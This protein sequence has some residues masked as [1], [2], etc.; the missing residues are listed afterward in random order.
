MPSE[1]PPLEAH[2][3]PAGVRPQEADVAGVVLH[4][5]LDVVAHL[6]RPVLVVTDADHQVVARQQAR[7]GVQVDR[8]R[9]VD[10]RGAERV[11]EEADRPYEVAEVHFIAAHTVRGVAALPA[12]P[13]TVESHLVGEVRG[14]EAVPGVDVA[15]AVAAVVRVGKAGGAGVVTGATPVVVGVEGRQRQDDQGVRLGAGVWPADDE[16]EVRGVLGGRGGVLEQRHVEAA[17]PVRRD[18]HRVRRQAAATGGIDIRRQRHRR[19]RGGDRD[20]EAGARCRLQA[21]GA[22]GVNLPDLHLE[23]SKEGG[24]HREVKVE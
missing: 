19:R 11:V 6:S 21:A 23:R 12:F 20:R 1:L 24:R 8:G 15:V 17:L 3:P 2:L 4:P 14:R 22:E 9:V 13:R 16:G 18:R 10:L 7:V 5:V